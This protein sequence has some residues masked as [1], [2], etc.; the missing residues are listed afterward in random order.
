VSA[1]PKKLPL[2]STSGFATAGARVASQSV[3]DHVAHPEVV[4][5]Q[6]SGGAEH[7]LEAQARYL[8]RRPT[9]TLPY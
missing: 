6:Y 8:R 2:Q 1:P 9:P 4:G 5:E 3:G 7:E